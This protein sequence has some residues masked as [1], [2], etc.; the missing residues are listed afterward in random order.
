MWTELEPDLRQSWITEGL[1]GEFSSYLCIGPFGL[2]ELASN[3]LKT[4]RDRWAYSFTK[5]SLVD[6][7]S[8]TID[9]YNGEVVRWKRRKNP[10]ADI[11]QFVRYDEKSISWSET[12][13]R[14]VANGNEISFREES[15]RTA[16]Y[17]P[18]CGGP[19]G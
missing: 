8:K 14:H 17:R 10:K 2:F 9:F 4:N 16:N 19:L 5:Q 18:Y 6:K 1:Q 7:V 11:D 15:I 12:L 13:K 3:G